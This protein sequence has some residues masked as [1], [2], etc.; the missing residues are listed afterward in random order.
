[1][2]RISG[3]RLRKWW[4]VAPRVCHVE[5]PDF[6]LLLL[7]QGYLLPLQDFP[8]R[9]PDSLLQGAQKGCLMDLGGLVLPLRLGVLILLRLLFLRMRTTDLWRIA[10]A[11]LFV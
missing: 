10:L 5:G 2:L 6:P 8:R 7:L 3:D 4:A 9:H 11:L 1:M